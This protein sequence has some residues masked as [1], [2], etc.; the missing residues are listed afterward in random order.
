MTE[1]TVYVCECVFVQEKSN[2]KQ[3]VMVSHGN[4]ESLVINRRVDVVVNRYAFE[5][6]DT[7]FIKDRNWIVLTIY[8]E[9]LDG[10]FK[11]RTVQL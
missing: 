2:L 1:V 8:R 7:E 10:L 11:I 3:E 9:N 6:N 5:K 4:F